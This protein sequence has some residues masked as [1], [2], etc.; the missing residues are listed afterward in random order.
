[1]ASGV[2]PSGFDLLSCGVGNFPESSEKVAAPIY[3]TKMTKGCFGL[4][5]RLKF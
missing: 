1:M 2:L 4:P 3:S 5:Q